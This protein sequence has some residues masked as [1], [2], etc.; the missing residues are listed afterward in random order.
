VRY[1]KVFNFQSGHRFYFF[2]YFF[3]FNSLS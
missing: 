2:F 3:L 1:L